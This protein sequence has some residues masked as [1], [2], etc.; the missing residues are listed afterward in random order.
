MCTSHGVFV[1]S[2]T[3]EIEDR[4][5]RTPVDTLAEWLE[6][7]EDI[8]RGA[9]AEA[10]RLVEDER[11]LRWVGDQNS[12]Q[13]VAPPPQFV[14]E[15]RCCLAIDCNSGEER[16]AAPWRPARS[17]AAKKWLQRFRQR[18][19]LT[20]GRLP[21][22]DVLPAATMQTKAR[23]RGHRKSRQWFPPSVDFGGR[24]ADRKMG[25]RSFFQ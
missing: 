19:N 16:G 14:W 18:W 23:S 1:A 13:G 20:L 10:Q 8:T 9:R 3:R 15:K 12:A 6:W 7:S 4:F 21:A 22:K 17:A 25:P 2:C 5:L 24:L 11:L